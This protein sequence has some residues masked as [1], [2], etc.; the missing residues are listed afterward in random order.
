MKD[1]GFHKE[2]LCKTRGHAGLCSEGTAFAPLAGAASGGLSVFDTFSNSSKVVLNMNRFKAKDALIT[3]LF[4]RLFTGM[5]CFPWLCPTLAQL[6][7]PGAVLTG[8]AGPS[9]ACTL[10]EGVVLL[11]T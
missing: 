1:S 4:R 10:H 2:G 3:Q 7:L 11:L 8:R 9:F 6:S 5:K